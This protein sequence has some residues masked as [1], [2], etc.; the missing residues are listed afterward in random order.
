M[1]VLV[2]YCKKKKKSRFEFQCK[3]RLWCIVMTVTLNAQK[4]RILE[5]Q[6]LWET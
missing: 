5:L 1:S 4:P 6:Q 3:K 2:I